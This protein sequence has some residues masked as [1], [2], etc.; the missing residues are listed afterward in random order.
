MY[1][2]TQM[3][4]QSTTSDF[5][6]LVKDNSCVAIVMLNSLDSINNSEVST[7]IS[8][9]IVYVIITIS[10]SRGNYSA[11]SNNMKLV[12]WP[13]KGGLLHLV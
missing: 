7:L 3:P 10:E 4:L 2:A 11:T 8:I 12:H 1:I 13:L 6:R 9:C 5:W